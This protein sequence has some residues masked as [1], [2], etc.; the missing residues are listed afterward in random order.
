M[1][2]YIAVFQHSSDPCPFYTVW[3]S[4]ESLLRLALVVAI[5][6]VVVSSST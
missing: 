6:V 4:S 1:H 3:H 5:T 2:A